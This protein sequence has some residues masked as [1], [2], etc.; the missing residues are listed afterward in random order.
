MSQ[1]IELEFFT[2]TFRE[3]LPRLASRDLSARATATA[4]F[5]A[6]C[7]ATRPEAGAFEQMLVVAGMM[8]LVVT[9]GVLNVSGAGLDEAFAKSGPM[10]VT[11]GA[12]DVP[13]QPAMFIRNQ[14]LNQE[15]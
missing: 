12:K 5:L 4:E 8:P 15:A 11:Y 1:T 3:L 13:F 9:Q 7:F 6:S 2:Q 14:A 10:L